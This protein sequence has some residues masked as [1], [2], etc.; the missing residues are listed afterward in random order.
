M[1]YMLMQA[2]NKFEKVKVTTTMSFYYFVP[3]QNT[4]KYNNELV[5]YTGIVKPNKNTF[6][7]N[8]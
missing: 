4:K 2:I 6:L 1:G 3:L 5:L 8:K 7:N